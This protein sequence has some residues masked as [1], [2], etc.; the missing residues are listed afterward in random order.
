VRTMRTGT[1]TAT[2][3]EAGKLAWTNVFLIISFSTGHLEVSKA[4]EIVMLGAFAYN[5]KLSVNVAYSIKVLR[6]V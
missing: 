6:L 4:L 2:A 3:T 1:E 5:I